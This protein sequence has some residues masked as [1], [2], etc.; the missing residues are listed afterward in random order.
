MNTRSNPVQVGSQ[1]KTPSCLFTK[2]ILP[3]G[4][5]SPGPCT[6]KTLHEG[7]TLTYSEVG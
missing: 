6:F 4:S 7:S 3:T 1:L 5:H 2:L